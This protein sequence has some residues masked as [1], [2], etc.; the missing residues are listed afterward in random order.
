MSHTPLSSSQSKILEGTAYFAVK[1]PRT[2]NES[3]P[4]IAVGRRIEEDS[5]CQGNIGYR[6]IENFI[7]FHEERGVFLKSLRALASQNPGYFFYCILLGLILTGRIGYQQIY[8]KMSIRDGKFSKG[9]RRT[10]PYCSPL[11]TLSAG[12]EPH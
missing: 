3:R 5:Y 12:K 4:I 6:L 1:G 11:Y 10:L 8:F 7:L 2:R 9:W